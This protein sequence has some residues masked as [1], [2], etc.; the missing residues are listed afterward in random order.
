MGI[1]AHLLRTQMLDCMETFAFRVRELAVETTVLASCCLA[2]FLRL[3]HVRGASEHI[4][5][6]AGVDQTD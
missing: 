2:T 6:H 4:G 3:K 5:L 1:A